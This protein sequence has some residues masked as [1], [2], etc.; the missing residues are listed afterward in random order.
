M[1]QSTHQPLVP[2]PRNAEAHAHVPT[3]AFYGHWPKHEQL[4]IVPGAAVQES[5]G[6]VATCAQDQARA[7]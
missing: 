3:M 5:I 4:E 6:T 7:I 1:A 2:S